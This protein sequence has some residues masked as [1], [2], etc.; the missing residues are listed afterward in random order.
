MKAFDIDTNVMTNDIV[1][2]KGK[3][4]LAMVRDEIEATS[5]PLSRHNLEYTRIS[6]LSKVI[7]LEGIKEMSISI[8]EQLFT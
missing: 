6:L 3:M 5:H 4:H 1:Y 7:E 2:R 8:V